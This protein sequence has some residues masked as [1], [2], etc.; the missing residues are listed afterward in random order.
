MSKFCYP[1]AQ[2]MRLLAYRTLLQ[3]VPFS[4]TEGERKQLIKKSICSSNIYMSE[5]MEL[6]PTVGGEGENIEC[7]V[8][9]EK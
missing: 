4:S 3:S 8:G 5:E 9:A 7:S 6:K 1:E 2:E